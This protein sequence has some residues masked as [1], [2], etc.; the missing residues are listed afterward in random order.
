M[1]QVRFIRTQLATGWSV[2]GDG[3]FA[4]LLR[5]VSANP[6]YERHLHR[7]AEWFVEF[8]EN[9]CPGREVGLDAAG[10]P[11][12]AGP[13]DENYGFWLSTNMRFGDFKGDRITQE[14][15]EEK[16]SAWH[17]ACGRRLM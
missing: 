4:K 7:V 10:K 13:D 12:I 16:W 17:T 8:D 9:G 1:Q 6:D 5:R 2:P 14:A 11:V 3:L 15:F